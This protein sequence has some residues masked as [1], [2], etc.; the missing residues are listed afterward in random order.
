MTNRSRLAEVLG[1]EEDEEFKINGYN[2]TYRIHNGIREF[3]FEEEWQWCDN[4]EALEAIINNPS[5]IQKKPRFTDEEM[6]LL[7]LLRKYGKVYK[8]GKGNGGTSCRTS[9]G[10][11]M[12]SNIGEIFKPGETI[13][14]DELFK[15]EEDGD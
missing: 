3:K 2:P 15:E 12:I 1:L 5:L 13:D 9:N 6:T 10:G 7:R 8:I 14:L 4:E 11:L